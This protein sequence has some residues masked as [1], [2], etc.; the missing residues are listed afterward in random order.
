MHEIHENPRKLSHH[1]LK[2]TT[3][4]GQDY[5]GAVNDFLINE[6]YYAKAKQNYLN[7]PI[8][9]YYTIKSSC[10]Q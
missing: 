1:N 5:P 3:K 4:Q 2:N 6:N 8:A 10:G 9:K 7:C